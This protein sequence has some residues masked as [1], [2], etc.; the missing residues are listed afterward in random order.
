MLLPNLVDYPAI[1]SLGSAGNSQTVQYR[2][3]RTPQPLPG[4]DPIQLADATAVDFNTNNLFGN[5]VVAG[6]PTVPTYNVDILFSATGGITNW[7]LGTDKIILWVRDTALNTAWDGD[8]HLITVFTRTGLIASY[9]ID[10]TP[11]PTG[12]LKPNQDPTTPLDPYTLTRSGESS[13]L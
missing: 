8:P 2:V 10:P 9:P 3:I 5:P 4:E 13:G 1:G 11:I 12:L 6:P 7:Q